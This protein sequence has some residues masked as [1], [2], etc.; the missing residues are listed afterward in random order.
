MDADVAVLDSGIADHPDL[1]IAGGINCTDTGGTAAAGWLDPTWAAPLSFDFIP[2]RGASRSHVLGGVA[3]RS[4]RT[5]IIGLAASILGS[6][7]ALGGPATAATGITYQLTL[8]DDCFAGSG[9][10]SKLLTFDL[11]RPN[12]TLAERVTDRTDS[13]GRFEACFNPNDVLGGWTLVAKRGTTK[14]RTF[15]IPNLTVVADRSDDT[16]KG[17]APAGRRVTIEVQDCTTDPA[18]CTTV[19]TRKLT[20]SAKGRYATD[21]TGDLDAVGQDLA[22]VRIKT[23]AGDTIAQTVAFPYFFVWR[24]QN[25][26][27]V[28]G[29]SGRSIVVERLDGPGGTVLGTHTITIP[30]NADGL[31]NLLFDAG[32]RFVADF[33]A[34]ATLDVP[35]ASIEWVQAGDIVQGIC[36]PSRPVVITRYG[37]QT[38]VVQADETGAYSLDVDANGGPADLTGSS[39]QIR[40]STAAGDHMVETKSL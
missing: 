21:V 20:A 33:E 16:V 18:T 29:K 31:W 9:P 32:D 40:C 22:L 15:Q 7:V 36:L 4:R 11:R 13:N 25:L 37:G 5:W 2:R 23:G 30:T 24:S 38:W 26:L 10:V 19:V 12:G 17:R 28:V 14:L 34:D 8:G 27:A 39:I 6:L 1:A 3:M 35:D